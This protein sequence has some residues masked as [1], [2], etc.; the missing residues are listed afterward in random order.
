MYLHLAGADTL[1]LENLVGEIDLLDPARQVTVTKEEN[2]Q[3][4][5]SRHYSPARAFTRVAAQLVSSTVS[6][7]KHK[8]AY[9]I[10]V[11]LDGD[12]VGELTAAMSARYQHLVVAAVKQ[13]GQADCEALITHGTRGLQI[14]LRLPAAN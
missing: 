8:G 10:E 2:H 13:S 4:V 5:L 9:A 11:R 12:R 14:D 7:G 3:T 6:A 1:L